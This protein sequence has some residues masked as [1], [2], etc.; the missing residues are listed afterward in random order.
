[1]PQSTK[2][3][4]LLSRTNE[5]TQIPTSE[6]TAALKTHEPTLQAKHNPHI[7][8]VRVTQCH[9]IAL[10]MA[11]VQ[12]IQNEKHSYVPVTTSVL[13]GMFCHL[14]TFRTICKQVL[15]LIQ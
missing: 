2:Y 9:H 7:R 11:Q 12:E 14:F 13:D 6:S 1:M 3:N 15:L 5:H 10:L 8:V 4:V